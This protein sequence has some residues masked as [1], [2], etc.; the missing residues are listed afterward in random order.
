MSKNKKQKVWDAP[1]RLMHWMLAASVAAAWYT[2]SRTGPVHEYIGYAAGAIVAM[3]LVWG[4]TGN[5][6]ARFAHFVRRPAPTLHYLREVVKARAARHIG[7]NPLGGWM[8]VAVLSCIALLTL[9]GWMMSTDLLWGYAWP[10]QL[11]EAI[12]WLLVGLIVLHVAGV[13][14]TS[15]THRE[16]LV[17]AMVSGKKAAPEPGDTD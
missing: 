13:L 14:F 11:H 7:H 12:A 4:F 9:T 6:Y 3:R 16:N 10:V 2:S 1:V 15:W 17:A 8:V 5:R